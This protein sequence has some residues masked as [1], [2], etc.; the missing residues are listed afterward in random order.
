VAAQ[1]AECDVLIIG[2]GGGSLEDLQAFNEE[3]L[4]RAIGDS[5]IPVVSGVGHEVDVTIADLVAD[6]RAP[7]PSGA[8]EL[9]VP[10]QREW[11]RTLAT[12]SVKLA[13]CIRRFQQDSAQTLDWL[14]RRL[15]QQAA[16]L[17][18]LGKSLAIAMRLDFTRRG[19]AVDRLLGRFLQ[20]SPAARIRHDSDR[21]ASLTRSLLRAGALPAEAARRRLQQAER[22]L[23]AVSP[24]AT[25]DRGYA[26]VSND[27]TGR[28]L[29][30]SDGIRPGDR[31]K[32]QLA[33][34]VL[35]AT[36]TGSEQ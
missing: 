32:A 4:A 20:Q 23:N 7:T 18:E 16:R 31:I 14:A 25:L 17:G 34:G 2:R 22:A 12:L 15:R 13:S 5:P 36:V 6:L 9:V 11:Q 24:L 27:E 3:A 21:L 8:A 1:R 28:I 29:L 30:D 19:R 33:R 26:I 10:D 35:R